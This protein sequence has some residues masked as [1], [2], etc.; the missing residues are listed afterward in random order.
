MYYYEK[1]YYKL[2]LK[3]IAG[4]DEVGRGCWAGPLVVCAV[5]LPENYLNNK[6]NDSK[7]LSKTKRSQLYE[8][9]IKDALA[10]SIIFT[11]SI[12]I[13]KV[14]I[15]QATVNA[16]KEAINKLSI[17]PDIVLIDAEE[18]KTKQKTKSIIK[19]D[20]KSISIAAASIVAKVTRDRYM[21]KIAK[22]YPQY[23]FEQHKGYGTIKHLKALKKYGPING[24]HRMSYKPIIQITKE[25]NQNVNSK[26]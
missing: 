18:V 23:Y 19:G 13:D 5:I 7:T 21:D 11:D 22:F 12:E 2:G 26:I 4:V 16:M 10:Y 8:V 14:N 3:T 1:K 25:L 20:S 17:K 9:I 15:K 24:F 6:I